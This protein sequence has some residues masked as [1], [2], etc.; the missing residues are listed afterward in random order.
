MPHADSAFVP[1]GINKSEFWEHVHGQ[2]A[3]LLEGQ[4]NWVTNLAN[5][6]SLIYSSLLSFH[7]HFGDENRAV[8]WCGFYIDSSLF[9]SPRI[10]QVNTELDE[11]IRTGQL[12]LG[13]FCG[14][15]A[16]QLINV[17]EG[18]ARG[19]CADA[20]LQRRTLLVPDVDNYPGH[21]A[22]DGDTRS[23]IVCPLILRNRGEE[24]PLGVLDLDCLALGGF[25]EE[26]RVGLQ[27]IADLVVRAC[28]W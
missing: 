2:L 11:T 8:N 5:A 28:D 16:C 18:K 6:S 9:P 21:I 4:R 27:S 20:Y 10:S 13:P 23:E 24:T 15:P 7:P 1:S 17:A 25:N 12:L 14:K 3:A 19:V 22:C 26:D